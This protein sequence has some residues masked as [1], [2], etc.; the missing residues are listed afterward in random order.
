MR[1]HGSSPRAANAP[2]QQLPPSSAQPQ[3]APSQEAVARLLRL[4]AAAG[5]QAEQLQALAR[6]LD[7][8]SVRSRLVG[9]DFKLPLKQVGRR[10]GAH[11]QDWLQG[12]R[13]LHCTA[14]P[15]FC[16]PGCSHEAG[17]C[18]PG[19]AATPP[20][21]L[22]TRMPCTPAC[23][24]LLT[25]SG[26]LPLPCPLAPLQLQLAAGQQAEALVGVAQ[27]MERLEKDIRDTGGG[28]SFAPRSGAHD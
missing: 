9:R 14:L 25:W 19:Q 16:M 23:A 4:E 1:A 28:A 26:W 7:K 24:C 2:F 5:Q 22:A 8:L 6:Q 18:M 21:S 3:R 27:R 11:L 20:A 12:P 10:G 15:A 17:A 13:P